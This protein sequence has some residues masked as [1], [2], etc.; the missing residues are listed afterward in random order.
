MQHILLTITMLL[1]GMASTSAQSNIQNKSREELIDFIKESIETYG[2]FMGI[3]YRV[4]YDAA[5]PNRL[6]IGEKADGDIKWFKID[7]SKASFGTSVSITATGKDNFFL[8]FRKDIT[9]KEKNNK[10]AGLDVAFF[11]RKDK[12]EADYGVLIEN[13]T[14]AFTSLISKCRV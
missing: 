3:D 6:R 10:N 9:I 4:S 14:L 12:R 7:L 8:S 11:R 1:L 2:N 13:L 5:E